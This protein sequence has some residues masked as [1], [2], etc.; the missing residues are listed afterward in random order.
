MDASDSSGIGAAAAE[1]KLVG[2]LACE[3]SALTAPYAEHALGQRDQQVADLL[4]RVEAE[5]ARHG[6]MVVAATPSALA[7]PVLSE[8]GRRG[9]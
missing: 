8:P 1:R 3:V 4:S 2:V 9:G 6:G 5:V 7:I